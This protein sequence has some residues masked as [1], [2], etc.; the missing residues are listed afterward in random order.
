MMAREY[1]NALP[2][3]LVIL[4]CQG[5]MPDA[6]PVSGTSEHKGGSQ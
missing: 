5:S 4:E 1:K 3:G 2:A 6:G